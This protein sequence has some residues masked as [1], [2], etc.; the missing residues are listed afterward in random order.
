MP[1]RDGLVQS[2]SRGQPPDQKAQLLFE[3][4]S[5]ANATSSEIKIY[6]A[7][8]TMWMRRFFCQQLSVCS[9]HAGFSLP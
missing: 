9:W 1:A 2:S 3:R 7:N 8:A 4:L 6:F 5:P